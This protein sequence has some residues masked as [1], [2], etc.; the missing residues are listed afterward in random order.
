MLLHIEDVS[1]PE[2][3]LLGWGGGAVELRIAITLESG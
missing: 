1:A 2:E 3:Q